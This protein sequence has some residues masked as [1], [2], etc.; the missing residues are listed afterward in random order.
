MSQVIEITFCHAEGPRFESITP[1]SRHE[2]I[3]GPVGSKSGVWVMGTGE[4]VLICFGEFKDTKEKADSP[5]L[6]VE[7]K[8]EVKPKA[9]VQGSPRKSKWNE[10]T[11]LEHAKTF[12]G[13]SEWNA[14][15][16]GSYSAAKRLGIFNQIKE[17]VFK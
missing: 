3:E 13:T 1:G 17:E 2:V 6:K 15:G 16:Y 4:P 7:V 8:S 5:L 11:I 14:K 10:E 12:K 9:V